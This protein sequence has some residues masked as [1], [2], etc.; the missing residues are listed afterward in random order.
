MLFI[1]ISILL[2]YLYCLGARR[3]QWIPFRPPF[4]TAG[5]RFI[6]NTSSSRIKLIS[7]SF[8]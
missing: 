4:A 5:E 2:V 6:E 1:S 8:Y 3:R 7:L